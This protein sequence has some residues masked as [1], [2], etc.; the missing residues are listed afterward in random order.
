MHL[1]TVWDTVRPRIARGDGREAAVLKDTAWVATAR[2]R[3]Q[4]IS[5]LMKCLKEPLSRLANRDTLKNVAGRLGVRFVWN[6]GG[7][8]V[9]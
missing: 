8:P 2:E 7:C 1:T 4:S 3:L 5:W 9:R 6:L